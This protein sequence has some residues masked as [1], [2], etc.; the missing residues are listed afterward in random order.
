VSFSS[1]QAPIGRPSSLC[2]VC[3]PRRKTLAIW[4]GDDDVDGIVSLLGGVIVEVLA[5]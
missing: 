2:T 4:S 3:F 1:L 5:L